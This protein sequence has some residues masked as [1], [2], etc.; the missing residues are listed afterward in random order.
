M[1]NPGKYGFRASLAKPYTIEE[2][3]EILNKMIEK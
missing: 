3:K 2:I 1:I